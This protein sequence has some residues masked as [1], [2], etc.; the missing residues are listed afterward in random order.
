VISQFALTGR[1]EAGA[2]IRSTQLYII[3][4]SE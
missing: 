1:I 4:E 3:A 2:L